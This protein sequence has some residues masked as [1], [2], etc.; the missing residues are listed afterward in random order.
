MSAGAPVVPAAALARRRRALLRA[1]RVRTARDALRFIDALGFCYAFTAGPGGLPGL[2]DVLATR[3]VDRMWTWAWRWKDE[4]ATRRRVYYGKAIR[5]KPSYVSLPL[6][7]AF[8]AL[9][10]NLGEP[11]D[12][13]Q[14]YREGRLSLQAREIYERILEAGPASTW[15][16][17]RAF[18]ARGER[19]S[20]FHRA[21][22]ELQERFLIA[23]VREEDE[24]RY[25]F[26]WDVFHRWMPGVV[27]TAAN[28][29]ADVAAG[30]VLAAYLGI[31]GAARAEDVR[32]LFGWSPA[33]LA[34]AAA[35]AG[36][37]EA[38]VAGRRGLTLPA[39]W[40]EFQRY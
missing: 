17:R 34:R 5:R 26:V 27:A 9:S 37:A 24:W 33:L 7:P 31:V 12:H 38:T 3:S 30:Q 10:G 19:G 23:K 14:A 39:A 21:L 18:L 22:D 36:A 16:L 11:D 32:A 13:L 2:F 8:Y 35:G 40:E 4:L 29:S 20:R 15:T 6:L 1:H 28:L 25:G